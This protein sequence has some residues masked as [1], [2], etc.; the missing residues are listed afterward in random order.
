MILTIDNP[1]D[2]VSSAFTRQNDLSFSLFI[3]TLHKWVEF[4]Y[5]ESSTTTLTWAFHHQE[6]S[7]A[8]KVMLIAESDIDKGIISRVQFLLHCKDQL[9]I[10]LPAQNVYA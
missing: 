1:N 5:Y 8:D 7:I 2:I 6:N 3:N 4:N 10:L 9:W